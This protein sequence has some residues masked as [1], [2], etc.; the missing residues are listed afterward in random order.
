MAETPQ[1]KHRFRPDDI[2]HLDTIVACLTSPAR[3]RVTRTDALRHALAA[4]AA[5]LSSPQHPEHRTR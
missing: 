2:Q 4:T 5:A 3:S 1:M